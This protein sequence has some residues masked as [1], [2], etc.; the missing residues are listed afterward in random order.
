MLSVLLFLVAAD[1]LL[2]DLGSI[3][4]EEEGQWKFRTGLFLY[5]DDANLLPSYD[6]SSY[7]PDADGVRR[8]RD[9]GRLAKYMGT[10]EAF[11]AKSGLKI[12]HKKTAIVSFHN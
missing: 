8:F 11:S 6:N 5:V 12:Y 7:P 1:Q 2:V 4:E 3:I 9:D 10:I